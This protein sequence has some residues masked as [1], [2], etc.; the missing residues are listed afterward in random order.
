VENSAGVMMS[1]SYSQWIFQGSASKGSDS[2]KEM[3]E[4]LRRLSISE[5]ATIW[6]AV[7]AELKNRL[8]KTEA[9]IF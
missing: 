9:A 7:V 3:R 1:K 2:V 6:R 5:L 4:Q 8:P